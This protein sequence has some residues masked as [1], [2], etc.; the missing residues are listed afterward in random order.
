MTGEA[1]DIGLDLSEIMFTGL[2]AGRRGTARPSRSVLGADV[3]VVARSQIGTSARDCDRGRAVP[4]LRGLPAPGS[5]THDDP[6][7]APII[8][9]LAQ[10]PLPESPFRCQR[11]SP[12]FCQRAD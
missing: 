5:S 10:P 6:D 9:V 1:L 3:N 2:R 8:R 4:L 11:S 7:P 12:V